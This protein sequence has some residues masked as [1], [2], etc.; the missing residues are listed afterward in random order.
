MPSF[1]ALVNSD[2]YTKQV[3]VDALMVFGNDTS[4]TTIVVPLPQGEG[5]LYPQSRRQIRI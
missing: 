1:I 4:S 3:F 2:K 5:F